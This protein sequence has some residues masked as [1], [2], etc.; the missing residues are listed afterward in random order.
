MARLVCEC[1]IVV[2]IIRARLLSLRVVSSNALC[3]SMGASPRS[4]ACKAWPVVVSLYHG[5]IRAR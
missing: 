5:P 1:R 2:V 4:R 3:G